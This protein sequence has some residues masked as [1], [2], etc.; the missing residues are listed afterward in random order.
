MTGGWELS[1]IDDDG[2]ANDDGLLC[3]RPVL[4]HGPLCH[5]P[6]AFVRHFQPFVADNAETQSSVFPVHLS[7]I[8]VTTR[9]TR[10][11]RGV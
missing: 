5:G 10:S 1:K 2:S 6:L 8:R 4:C 11:V 3:R 7:G 9:R